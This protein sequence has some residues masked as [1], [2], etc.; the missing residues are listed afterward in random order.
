MGTCR[1]PINYKQIADQMGRS[2][3]GS[4]YVVSL[5]STECG[6]SQSG[7]ALSASTAPLYSYIPRIIHGA[8]TTPLFRMYIPATYISELRSGGWRQN[9][10]LADFTFEHSGQL[11]DLGNIKI[12]CEVCLKDSRL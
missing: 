2:E 9:L 5:T 11:Y 3:T 12:S 8:P 6:D 1:T 10:T 7:T 4:E